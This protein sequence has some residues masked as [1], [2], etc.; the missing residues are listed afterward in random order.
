[1][2]PAKIE[3]KT[4]CF[5]FDIWC[6]EGV[7]LLHFSETSNSWYF[8]LEHLMHLILEFLDPILIQT[9][10]NSIQHILSPNLVGHREKNHRLAMGRTKV[11]PLARNEVTNL[12]T[13]D[14]R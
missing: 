4:R 6:A 5:E 12:R 10:P 9:H 8:D 1:M 3:Y 7:C 11:E 2:P 13:Y 14:V